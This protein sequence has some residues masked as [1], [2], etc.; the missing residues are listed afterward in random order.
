MRFTNKCLCIIVVFLLGAGTSLAQFSSNVQG[1]VFDESE[2]VIPGATVVLTENATAIERTAI[3]GPSGIYRF[4]GLAPG[5]YQLRFELPG[6]QVTVIPV[7]LL[8]KQTVE[9]NATLVVR[10]TADLVLVTGESPTLDTADSRLQSTVEEEIL[11]DLPLQGRNMLGL[12]AVAPGVTGYGNVAGGAPGNAPDNYSTEVVIDASGNGRNSSGNLYTVDGLNITSNIIQGVANLAPNPDSIQEFSIQTNTFSVEQT[13]ASSIQVAITTKGG[14]NEF[15]GSGSYYF[16]NQ[17][18]WARTVF[19]GERRPFKKQLFNGTLGGPIVKNK[20]FFFASL[21]GLRSEISQADSVRTFES[22]EFVNWARQNF[23]DTLGTNVLSER[24]PSDALIA[25]VA[26]TAED[27]FGSGPEGCGTASTS[28][29]PCSLAMINEGRFTRSPFRNGLQYNVRVDQYLNDSADRLYFNLYRT[30][31][32]IETQRN[33]RG[34]ST[35]D[36]NFSTAIQSSW[37]RTFSP[38]VINEFSFGW[39]RVQG[40]RGFNE[41]TEGG[42]I[43]FNIPNINVQGQSLG[44]S[45]AWG[46]ATFIQ[47]NFNW[48]NVVSVLKG[49][50]SLRFGVSGWWGDDDARFNDVF[51]RTTLGFNNLLDLVSDSPFTQG[52]PLIDPLTGLEGPGGYE[53]LLNTFGWFIQDEWKVTPRL[54]LTLGIRWD[55]FGNITRNEDKGVILGN[56]FLPQQFSTLGSPAEIDA[57]FADA[58]VRF[59]DEGIYGGRITNNWAPRAGIAWDPTGDGTWVVRGGFGLYHDWIPLGEA[60]RIRGNPPGLVGLS[61]RRGDPSSPEPIF[62]IGTSTSFPFGWVLPQFATLELDERGGIL[63]ARSSVGG[64]DRHIEPSDTYNFMIG[65]ERRL[66]RDLVLGVM[67]SGSR[68]RN[69]IVGNDMNRFEGDL[70]DGV[71][72]RLNPSFG[73]VFYEFNGNEI[74]YNAVIASFRGRFR[75]GGSFQ[76]S[77]T[78]SKTEDF[79]QAGS[80]VNRDPGF[81]TPSQHNLERFKGPADWDFRNR[82]S[83]SG[84]YQLPTPDTGGFARRVLGGWEF[85]TVAVLQSGPPFTVVSTASFQPQL[86]ADGNVVGFLPGSG[87]FNADGVNFDFP[88]APATDFTGSHSRQDFINGLF[89]AADF[90]LPT[91][92]TLGNL[93]RQP[94]RGPGLANVDFTVIKNNQISEDVN[95][96]LRFEFFNILNRVN[97]SNVEGR[98]DRSTFGRSTSTFNPRIIQLGVRLTF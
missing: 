73:R 95:L 55:D 98:M 10:G 45:P 56:V 25:G 50:H 19:T 78:L 36:D 76:A 24:R 63:G 26:R 84:L 51:G 13:N 49:S 7:R 23:P 29:I 52:G 90:P 32:D 64:I 18:L 38:A 12:A 71:L 22:E 43:P 79:G 59:T 97:L 88:N 3:T 65:V 57:A 93:E 20:T 91:P 9:V 94:F 60:N 37:T 27:V 67:Y 6:F 15:H 83:L 31:L 68:T 28:F 69:G 14:T 74:D 58:S 40:N 80:R 17:D 46:P 39:I 96:Q 48:R 4:T 21:E 42:P 75:R 47:N 16:T 86:D 2:A 70:L 5:D 92:G 8:T 34:F 11:D 87:D 61:S 35:T 54:T 53:H 72:D 1:I 44:I 30:E 62:S 81:A 41:S 85:G 82:F 77:Y 89:T 33:R 66:P